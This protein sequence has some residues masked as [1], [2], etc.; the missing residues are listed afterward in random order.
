MMVQ[1]TKVMTNETIRGT[2]A[3]IFKSK[4]YRWWN[5]MLP[6]RRACGPSGCVAFMIYS[7]R[8]KLLASS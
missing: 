3:R 8:L 7:T 6:L 5:R 1:Y 2:A 4:L